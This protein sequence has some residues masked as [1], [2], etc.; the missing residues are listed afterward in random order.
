V[1]HCVKIREFGSPK[2]ELH[3][4]LTPNCGLTFSAFF[5]VN[6]VRPKKVDDSEPVTVADRDDNFIDLSLSAV[7]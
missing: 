2:R 7:V 1:L 6:L 3:G 4:N 5:A